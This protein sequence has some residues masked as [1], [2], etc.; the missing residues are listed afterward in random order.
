MNP[1][2]SETERALLTTLLEKYPEWL[3]RALCRYAALPAE[4]LRFFVPDSGRGALQPYVRLLVQNTALYWEP[5]SFVSL[6]C[7][8]GTYPY[9][10][11][12]DRNLNALNKMFLLQHPAFPFSL[13]QQPL[14]NLNADILPG[15]C[16][17]PRFP[18]NADF[19]YQQMEHL[20]WEGLSSNCHLPWSEEMFEA[21]KDEWDWSESINLNPA[22]PW[23]EAFLAKY[24]DLWEWPQ[25]SR[26]PALPWSLALL[27][28]Y[29]ERWDWNWLSL[30]PSLPWSEA[31]LSRFAE[32]WNWRLLSQ[33]PSL[34]W[35]EAMLETYL[36]R[37]NWSVLSGNPG[38]PWQAGVFE[39][40]FERWDWLRL[41]GN[42]GLPWSQAFLAQYAERWNWVGP[43]GLSSNPG[44]PW[45]LDLIQAWQDRWIQPGVAPFSRNQGLAWRLEWLEA[46]EPLLEAVPQGLG[47]EG[48]CLNEATE[49]SLDLL[50]ALEQRGKVEPYLG[51]L[52]LNPRI[53]SRVLSPFE[54]SLTQLCLSQI[55]AEAP[56][57]TKDKN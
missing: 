31:L 14:L 32:R 46:C 37:W 22:L 1:A 20:S 25:L 2:V 44:L 6:F 3:K 5:D 27:E 11:N 48:L 53:W 39:R 40:Y 57:V 36:E 19:I 45:D 47:W 7:G 13:L 35:T 54:E 29:A 33:N 10:Y 28:K 21:F 18:W 12:L 15:L 43:G 42:T 56:V 49:W 9:E 55:S 52:S 30:N 26:N 17:H 16:D 34:G 51:C 41:S 50:L 4:S 24:A 8:S 23:S 38:L